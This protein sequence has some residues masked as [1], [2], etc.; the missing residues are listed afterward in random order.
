MTAAPID[1]EALKLAVLAYDKAR[2]ATHGALERPM[3]DR[4]RETIAP[5]I[6]AAIEAYNAAVKP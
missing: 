4:N 6:A 5:M 3:S 2:C 1:R